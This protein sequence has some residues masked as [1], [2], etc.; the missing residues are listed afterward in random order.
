M[1]N[2]AIEPGLKDNESM[3]NDL[4]ADALAIKAEALMRKNGNQATPECRP[5]IV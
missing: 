5:G 2:L 4:V 3:S 1:W